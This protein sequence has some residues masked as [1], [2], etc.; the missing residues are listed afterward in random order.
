LRASGRTFGP[1]QGCS[2]RTSASTHW[3]SAPCRA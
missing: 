3:S 1:A 2:Q